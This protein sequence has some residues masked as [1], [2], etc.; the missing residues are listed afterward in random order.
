M[1][2]PILTI[3]YRT[4]PDYTVPPNSLPI[5]RAP[6]LNPHD[7]KATTD[8]LESVCQSL[9]RRPVVGGRH[10]IFLIFDAAGGGGGGAERSRV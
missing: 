5:F 8:G 7:L 3:L 6:S 4:I 1:Y 2:V 10:F 9:R